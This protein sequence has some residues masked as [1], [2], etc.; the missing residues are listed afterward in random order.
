[1]TITKSNYEVG[2][3]NTSFEGFHQSLFQMYWLAN[4]SASHKQK[5]NE[6][7]N[8]FRRYSN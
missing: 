8:N 4:S 2:V 5:F 3:C 1:M 7:L 6:E